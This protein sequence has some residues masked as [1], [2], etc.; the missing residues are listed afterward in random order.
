MSDMTADTRESFASRTRRQAREEL[1]RVAEAK[2]EI[3]AQIESLRGQYALMELE[4]EAANGVLMALD[5]ALARAREA[6][7]AERELE[8][9]LAARHPALA[10]VA[11]L[12]GAEPGTT[13][14]GDGVTATVS[15]G[16]PYDGEAHPIE[17]E[18]SADASPADLP[19][20]GTAVSTVETAEPETPVEENGNGR[21]LR[22]AEIERRRKL[23]VVLAYA[24]DHDTFT[25]SDIAGVLDMSNQGARLILNTLIRDGALRELP[26]ENGTTPI[27][28]EKVEVGDPESTPSALPGDRAQA[29]DSDGGEPGARQRKTPVACS[30]E[31]VRDYVQAELRSA[32][33]FSPSVVSDA[34]GCSRGTA[35][36]YLNEM[37]EKGTI[38]KHGTVGRYVRYE[39]VRARDAGIRSP[40]HAPRSQ[41]PHGPRPMRPPSRNGSGEVVPHTGRG[42]GRTGKPGLDRKLAAQGFKVR[43]RKK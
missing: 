20:D 36:K 10:A 39:F 16:P 24:G 28:F 7:N 30:F 23:G 5:A 3:E 27:Y 21:T 34:L 43:A 40:T 4:Q 35:T 42:K 13:V 9:D 2:T 6:D 18:S 14:E 38:V 17:P 33:R 37:V 11:D 19:A 41:G 32:G 29:A 1:Q 31:Q 25:T 8:D 12:A 26:R 15:A 22:P